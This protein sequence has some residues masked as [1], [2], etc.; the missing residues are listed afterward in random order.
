MS[1]EKLLIKKAKDNPKR[2]IFPEADFSDRIIEA[3]IKIARAK[4]ADVIFVGDEASLSLKIGQRDLSKIK[5]YNPQK[6][7]IYDSLLK[8]LLLKRKD[9]GLKEKEAKELLLDP[10]YFA[11]VLT[12]LGYADGMIAGAEVSSAKTLKPALQV[13]KGK[14]GLVSSYFLFVGKNMV[15][16]DCFMMGDCA[17]VEN[18]T[19]EQE[20]KIASLML[21]EC[22][23][24]DI[25]MPR[26]AFLSYS[27]NGSA[28]S[29][30][31]DK[32][33]RACELFKEQNK[34]VYAI[35]EVQLD[36]SIKERV[37]KVKMGDVNGFKPA[38][39]FV[40]PNIDA[41][42]ICY[43]AVQYFGGLEAIGPITMGFNK[44]VNDLSRGCTVKDI[45]MLTAITVL[46]CD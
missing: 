17:L 14:D 5:I 4:I 10:I 43:K 28:K 11:T 39:V 20:A 36:A 41:G 1:I 45:I 18:P 21:A 24:Y 27:T 8:H 29:D 15:T 31:V 34:G 37:A 3:G 2:I 32:V 25:A 16:D 30:A 7:D 22:K 19:A 23:R 33:A 6:C 9:K 40:M 35:G 46:Q 26:F 44:P 42:N 12:D 13:I 38:N